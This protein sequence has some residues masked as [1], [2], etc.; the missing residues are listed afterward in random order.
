MD[1]RAWF[2]LVMALV[3]VGFIFGALV[4]LSTSPRMDGP[5]VHARDI[6]W[7]PAPKGWSWALVHGTSKPYLTDVVLE[8]LPQTNLRSWGVVSY[9]QPI[10]RRTQQEITAACGR[11]MAMYRLDQ[12]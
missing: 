5:D 1:G 9:Y 12:R 10:R 7:P 6:K 4:Y 11:V 2:Y 3:M 8:P